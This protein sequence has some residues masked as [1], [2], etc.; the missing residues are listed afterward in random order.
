MS[1]DEVLTVVVVRKAVAAAVHAHCSPANVRSLSETQLCA[2]PWAAAAAGGP[3]AN[4]DALLLAFFSLGRPIWPTC[5]LVHCIDWLSLASMLL[6][7]CACRYLLSTTRSVWRGDIDIM[8]LS[9]SSERC[10]PEHSGEAEALASRLPVLSV[11]RRRN[12]SSASAHLR[13]PPLVNSVRRGGAISQILC[14]AAFFL[15]LLLPALLSLI[16]HANMHA[17][18][19]QCSGVGFI[20]Q[21]F[22]RLAKSIVWLARLE[23]MNAMQSTN[24][25]DSLS[26]G[27]R[28]RGGGGGT[29]EKPVRSTPVVSNAEKKVRREQR[30]TC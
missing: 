11:R 8:R 22:V 3:N 23:S 19:S 15:A 26:Y 13:A 2:T 10:A 6:S 1:A 12:A 24:E 21:F 28:D 4:D 7:V 30:K 27:G 29:R 20:V 18:N 5:M 25:G 17:C 9:G 16:V 14:A